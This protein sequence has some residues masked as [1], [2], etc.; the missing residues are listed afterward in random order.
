MALAFAITQPHHQALY[1]PK[2]VY[3]L[4][5]LY[6]Q[7]DQHTSCV[8]YILVL[9]NKSVIKEPDL[10]ERLKVISSTNNPRVIQTKGEQCSRNFSQIWKF[11]GRQLRCL[12]CLHALI[13]RY[14]DANAMF[15]LEGKSDL[16]FYDL[17]L[18]NSS[19]S[20]NSSL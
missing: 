15:F 10:S 2:P 14:T 3:F 9:L 7:T 16:D 5:L 6:S 20:S 1:I 13:V 11:S 18:L 19:I 17:S 8:L 4:T 12:L